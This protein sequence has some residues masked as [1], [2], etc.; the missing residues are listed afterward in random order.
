M[1]GHA[2]NIGGG[3]SDEQLLIPAAGT[4]IQIPEDDQITVGQLKMGYGPKSIDI[5]KNVPD[6][7]NLY[8]IELDLAATTPEMAT[9]LGEGYRTK[10]GFITATDANGKYEGFDIN[11]SDINNMNLEDLLFNAST[12]KGIC[13]GDD[14]YMVMT[15]YSLKK[16]DDV[17]IWVLFTKPGNPLPRL[18]YVDIVLP[19]PF[20]TIVVKPEFAAIPI[21]DTSF[22]QMM[23][24]AFFQ[25]TPPLEGN[26]LPA[27]FDAFTADEHYVL[28][29]KEYDFSKISTISISVP[30]G[31]VSTPP[32]S[33]WNPTP[34]QQITM[35]APP[36][37]TSNIFSHFNG[38][39][40]GA[41]YTIKNLKYMPQSTSVINDFGFF[42]EISGTVKNLNLI[43]DDVSDENAA[44]GVIN[45]GGLGGST[46]N[47]EIKEISVSSSTT[48]H[49]PYLFNN[50][51]HSNTTLRM[52]GIV[53]L[54]D[55]Q[56][57]IS[58][59]NNSQ[60]VVDPSSTNPPGGLY[61]NQ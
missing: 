28:I 34:M 58:S 49:L 33:P 53:G 52:G 25:G 14:W 45:F 9:L 21:A 3:V 16:D 2:N 51:L 6:L 23:L 10:L 24:M 59:T 38:I 13:G 36:I 35:L 18:Y 41:G 20:D 7:P 44:H 37:Q 17:R 8:K 43:I 57:T 15:D 47:A 42:G 50:R 26:L 54:K 56:T 11:I 22:F 19:E 1:P 5:L 46:V 31:T 40:D 39:F 61:N 32:L 55:S 48:T 27:P 60:S 4:E 30:G 12:V 29:K